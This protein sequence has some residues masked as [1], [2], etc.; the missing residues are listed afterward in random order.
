MP[1]ILGLFCKAPSKL[2]TD[3]NSRKLLEILKN[4]HKQSTVDLILYD[5]YAFRFRS[6]NVR[7]YFSPAFLYWLL[8]NSIW[9][10]IRKFF[11]ARLS[12]LRN[13]FGNLDSV[14]QFHGVCKRVVLRALGMWSGSYSDSLRQMHSR[15]APADGSMEDLKFRQRMLYRIYICQELQI[16]ATD[17]WVRISSV[18][19]SRQE[20]SPELEVLGD[21]L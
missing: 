20:H 19:Q 21:L 14:L 10:S 12:Q 6:Y 17:K 16:T 1:Y 18:C 7:V 2:R 8:M 15:H 11:R 9:P 13:S 3:T 5:C 4:S